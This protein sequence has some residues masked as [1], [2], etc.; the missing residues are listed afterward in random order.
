MFL[1]ERMESSY[2]M[3][4][5]LFKIEYIFFFLVELIEFGFLGIFF[6]F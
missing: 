6:G 1:I 3:L 5:I 4:D 2:V